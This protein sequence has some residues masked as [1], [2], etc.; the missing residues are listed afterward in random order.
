MRSDLRFG[1]TEKRIWHRIEAQQEGNQQ[2][3]GFLKAIETL[4][5]DNDFSIVPMTGDMQSLPSSNLEEPSA[6]RSQAVKWIQ[7]D[8]LCSDCIV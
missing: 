8:E 6:H 3:V 7:F 4:I 2:F 1:E 5:Q